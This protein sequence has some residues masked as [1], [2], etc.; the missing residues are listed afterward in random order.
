MRIQGSVKTLRSFR[1]LKYS[2]GISYCGWDVGIYDVVIS[3]DN[4]NPEVVSCVHTYLE[5]L[6]INLLFKY[7]LF[8][9]EHSEGRTKQDGI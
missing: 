6:R 9:W 5:T 3:Q 1:L 4:T 7:D 8:S 2:E